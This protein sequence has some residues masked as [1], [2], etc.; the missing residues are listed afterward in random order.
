MTEHPPPARTRVL[1]SGAS[2]AGPA[3][4]ALLAAAGFAV[5]VLER[6]PALREGGQNIDVRAT[7]REVLRRLGLEDAVRARSTGEVGTR[8]VDEDG[9]TVAE[10]GVDDREGTDG[11]TAELEILRGA[12][13]RIL[14]DAC[15]DDVTWRFGDH[16]VAVEQDDD[17]V[18][19]VLA[20]GD[21]ERYDLLIVAE[22]VGSATRSL[23]LGDEVEERPLGMYA[24][25]GTIA[26]TADDDD[27][28]RALIAPGSRQASLRPDDVGTT[29]ANLN[30]LVG[31]PVLADLDEAGTR[32]ALRERFAGVGW[33]VPRILDGFDAADDLYV[34]WL[35]QVR[36]PTWHR[37]RVCLLGDAAWCVTPIGGGGASLA[38]TGAYVLAAYLS[39]ADGTGDGW[40]RAFASYEDWL[41]PVVDEA[42]DLPPGVP[43]IAAPSSRAGVQ[44]LRWG[45]KVAALPPVRTIAQRLTSGPEAE[46]ELPEV[47]EPS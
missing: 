5:T 27:W 41:R 38:L 22:G 46:E 28:W 23:V 6:A 8:F 19:V 29:R 11:P 10:F 7:G 13:S 40:A 15:P 33:E 30:F 14:V 37:G 3:V 47:R 36:S 2:V 1:V 44:V 31:E 39:Q 20:S 32:A 26:R 45:T 24:A 12:L 25:Y 4:A 18:D 16:V 42:Q 9:G 34:D 43:R 21:R 17:G 35:R